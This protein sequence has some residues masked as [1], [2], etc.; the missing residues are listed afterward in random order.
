MKRVLHHETIRP[1]LLRCIKSQLSLVRKAWWRTAGLHSQRCSQMSQRDARRCILPVEVL[2]LLSF[3]V[4]ING[5]QLPLAVMGF[6][7]SGLLSCWD[8][9]SRT[10]AVQRNIS[11]CFLR[12][13]IGGGCHCLKWSMFTKTNAIQLNNPTSSWVSS[14][15]SIVALP[16]FLTM[17]ASK[18]RSRQTKNKLVILLQKLFSYSRKSQNPDTWEGQYCF[19]WICTFAKE[20]PESSPRQHPE[21]KSLKA[22]AF[23]LTSWSDFVRMWTSE[24]VRTLY[25]NS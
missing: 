10:C 13:N 20:L 19:F 18:N 7:F 15:L 17:S 3:I 12:N 1:G 4:R 14:Q 11:G 22:I 24:T 23:T 5:S 21:Q 9:Y 25:Q 2:P 6:R 16:R 8:N